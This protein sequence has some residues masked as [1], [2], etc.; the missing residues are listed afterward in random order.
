MAQAICDNVPDGGTIVEIM[1]PETD[2]NVA[3]VMNGFDSVCS[4]HDMNVS[5]KYNCENWR[6]E[7]AYEFVSDNFEEIAEADHVR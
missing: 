6:P 4:E 3:Q 2:Y 5:L 1:G 7:L